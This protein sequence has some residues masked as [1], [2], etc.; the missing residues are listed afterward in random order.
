M[1]RY[2]CVLLI[3]ICQFSFGQ[4]D[5]ILKF[6][7]FYGSFGTSSPMT[8]NSFFNV[9]GEYGIDTEMLTETNRDLDVDFKWN[10]GVRKIARF[11]YEQREIFYDGTE[12]TKGQ[13]TNKGAVEG[14][15]FMFEYSKF[16][17][18]G[19]SGV[20][21][22]YFV[23][24]LD[25]WWFVRGDYTSI[26][27]QDIEF[28]SVDLRGRYDLL[29]GLSFNGG[30]TSRWHR[31]YGCDPFEMWM[32]NNPDA[33]WYIFAYEQGYDDV[34]WYYD[35]EQNGIDDYYDYWDW[36]WYDEQGEL[37]AY[38]D[39]EFYNYHFGNIVNEFRETEL[40]KLDKQHLMSLSFGLDYYKHSDNFWIHSWANVM[41]YHFGF[42]W[43]GDDEHSYISYNNNEQWL[44]WNI[45]IVLGS[46]ISKKFG[47]FVEGDYNDFWG[48][49]W[50]QAKA[51][52]NY[53]FF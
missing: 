11:D 24:Y 35:G 12:Q 45:G 4:I 10:I 2:I 26:E 9:S 30:V 18:Q 14:L 31:T 29:N 41:P 19:V 40:G 20:D 48:Q 33:P 51:G 49:K 1:M 50:Y 17:E 32:I 8:Q 34:Y 13:L 27:L 39:H 53:I 52:I 16:R 3:F 6:S 7:T 23:R 46:K 25:K 38:S 21:R 43:L 15:E 44:D 37:I 28:A 22:K 47:L 36:Y 42:G 5:D